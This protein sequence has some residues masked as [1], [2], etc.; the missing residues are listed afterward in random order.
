MKPVRWLSVLPA[1]CLFLP[2]C[3]ICARENFD[4]SAPPPSL[5]NSG[6]SP[7]SPARI[8][9]IVKDP[10]GAVVPGAR[11]EITNRNSGS[12]FATTTDDLGRFSFEAIAQGRY[13]LR[14]IAPGFDQ[15]TV[16]A[17]VVGAHGLSID[18]SLHIAVPRTTVEVKAPLLGSASE[19]LVEPALAGQAQTANT[20]QLLARTPGVTLRENG[21]LGSIPMLHG[22]GDERTKLVVDGMTVSSACPNHMNPPASYIASSHLARMTVMPGITPVSLGGDSLGGTVAIESADPAFAGMDQRLNATVNSSGFYRSNGGNYGGSF[23]EW[24]AGRHLGVGYSG[25]WATSDNYQD[26]SGHKITSTYAQTTEHALVLAA[27]GANNF[28]ALRAGLHHVPY[29]GFPSAQMDMVRDHAESLN[30]HYRRSLEHGSL[31]AHVYWQ[32]AWHSMNI[33][34]DKSTFPTPMW[35]P[36]N[37]HGRD[38]GYTWKLD[39]PIAARHNLAAGN[40]IHRFVLDDRWPA[41]P[42][43]GMAPDDFISINN[44]RRMRMGWFAELASDWS[45]RWTTLL[46]LR[47]DTVWMNTGAVHGY[48]MMY[49]ADANAFNAAHRARRDDGLDATAWTRYQPNPGTTFELGYARKTRAPNLYERY[50]WST[51]KMISGMIGWFGDG[52]YYVGN[53]AL[54]PE[55]ADT[56]GGTA[57]W[58]DPANAH[59]DLKATA[60]V[61]SLHDFVDVDTL[62][63]YKYSQATLAQLRFANYDARIAGADLSG[64]RTLWQNDRLGLGR[65]AVLAGWQHGNRTDTSTGLYQMM[66]LHAR[67]AFDEQKSGFTA[68]AGIALFDRKSHLDPTR[69]EKAT[70]GYALLDLRGGYEHG[71]LRIAGGAD[72]LLNRCYASPLGGVNFDDFMAGGRKSELNPLTGRGRSVYF[73]LSAQF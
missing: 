67:F 63:T 10:S 45:P 5:T 15:E 69:F 13:E 53:L 56:I 2:A 42:G 50:A 30:L 68:G 11:I 58:N 8:S 17:L 40:E 6:G 72:N 12:T 57:A 66:P 61:T 36:M 48:S 64:A 43:T 4:A 22:L 55:A 73:A 19:T 26:G 25:S 33:G 54:R 29:E 52:N 27:R 62:K 38:S 70:P 35:M 14:T 9:G 24:V 51:S 31:D 28:V 20:A 41:V 32:G 16:P 3:P 37:T 49:A 23:T 71:H 47:S 60:W 46:G 59:W 7:T 65:L 34:K 21:T 39:L 18:I 44:G 1:V